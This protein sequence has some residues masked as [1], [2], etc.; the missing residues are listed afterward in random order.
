[1][2]SYPSTPLS[3]KPDPPRGAPERR[4]RAVRAASP[5]RSATSRILGELPAPLLTLIDLLVVMAAEPW[6]LVR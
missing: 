4:L 1:M 5:E 3:P 2:T 6:L